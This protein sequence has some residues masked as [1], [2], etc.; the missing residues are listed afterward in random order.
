MKALSD[1]VAAKL[2]PRGARAALLQ[3]IGAG[4]ITAGAWVL[5]PA[6]GLITAGVL[7]FVLAGLSE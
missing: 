2:R 1:I 7:L 6:A 3:L 5:L 4:L